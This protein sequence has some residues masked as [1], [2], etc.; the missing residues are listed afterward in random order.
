M[1]GPGS[2]LP[3]PIGYAIVGFIVAGSL[4]AAWHGDYGPLE[5]VLFVAGFCFAVR[6]ACEWRDSRL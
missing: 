2:S 6:A 4:V 5:V 1:T 3:D